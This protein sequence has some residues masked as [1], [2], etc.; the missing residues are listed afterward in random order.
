MITK[1]E[2]LN[3]VKSSDHRMVRATIKLSL[4]KE[5]KR[6]LNQSLDL[7]PTTN[8][9]NLLEFQNELCAAT[10]LVALK[11]DHKLTDI[12]Q[13]YNA[14]ISPLVQTTL[15]YLK[16]Q[17]QKKIHSKYSQINGKT[18][19]LNP[20]STRNKVEETELNKLIKRQQRQDIQSHYVKTIEETI[21]QGKRFEQAQQKVWFGKQIIPSIKKENENITTIQNRILER[22]KKYYE[23]L[24]HCDLCKPL[25]LLNSA[26]IEIPLITVVVVVVAHFYPPVTGQRQTLTFRTIR[27][28]FITTTTP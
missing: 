23:K 9:E 6:F 7:L 21:K 19:N 25:P 16:T 4:Q 18:Q 5:R 24:Y 22:C 28:L 13:I 17:E 2:I 20:T 26:K 27:T 11:S 10:D 3:C 14:I 8:K 12:E 1:T 15:K